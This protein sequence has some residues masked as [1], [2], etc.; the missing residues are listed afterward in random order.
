MNALHRYCSFQN[1]YRAL[2]GVAAGSLEPMYEGQKTLE[3]GRENDVVKAAAVA[4]KP[5]VPL[6]KRYIESRKWNIERRPA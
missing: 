1:D 4:A 3:R 6:P 2:L 5:A